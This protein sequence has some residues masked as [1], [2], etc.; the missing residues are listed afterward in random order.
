MSAEVDSRPPFI[1]NSYS[2]RSPLT[3]PAP[4]RCYHGLIC[5][6]PQLP[7]YGCCLIGQLSPKLCT[8]HSL[9]AYVKSK[10]P[11]LRNQDAQKSMLALTQAFSIERQVAK[12][13]TSCDRVVESLILRHQPV[14]CRMQRLFLLCPIIGAGSHHCRVT[15][16]L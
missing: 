2:A 16:L 6:R 13:Y 1:Q 15:P 5:L 12:R 7:G 11:R 14:K 10:S 4:G 9:T 8:P 3:V